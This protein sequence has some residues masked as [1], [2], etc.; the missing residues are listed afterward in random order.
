MYWNGI[1]ATN[2][3]CPLHIKPSLGLA[4]LTA[5]ELWTFPTEITC[6][7]KGENPPTYVFFSKN[8]CG[9]DFALHRDRR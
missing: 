2:H 3:L 6:K 9:M 8:V 7:V 1:P 5:V 4:R